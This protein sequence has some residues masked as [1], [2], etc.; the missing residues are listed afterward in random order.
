MRTV[1]KTGASTSSFST[2]MRRPTR[3][4]PPKPQPS[5]RD[6]NDVDA[7][8]RRNRRA[9]QSALVAG[10]RV[11]RRSKAA[12][13]SRST[14]AS[15]SGSRSF[16]PTS[17]RRCG[18]CTTTS[19]VC[20]TTRSRSTCAPASRR[21]SS[22]SNR[23]RYG[24]FIASIGIPSILS[25]FSMDPLA[26]SGI[27]Q[28]DLNLAFSILDRLLGG[29]GWYPDQAARSLRHR[30]HA[31]AAL[32]GPHAQQL[33]RGLE[34]PADALAE[35][36]SAGLEPAVHPAHHPARP[37]RRLRLLRAQDRRHRRRHE[38]RPARTPFSNRSGRSS[39]TTS[40]RPRSWPAAV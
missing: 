20:S 15:T 21:R 8:A 18:R 34:L 9:R 6:S 35:D 14:S 31:D 2:P 29:P 24:D 22:R 30:A 36:R 13:S 40:G 25:I 12:R 17:S 33:P 16:S 1:R 10:R 37:D 11:S 23:S 4:L 28:V 27:V 19:R 26:G 32:H 39:P 3:K 7:L 38:L 5:P